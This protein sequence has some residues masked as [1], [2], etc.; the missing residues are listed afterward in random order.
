MIISVVTWLL[1]GGLVLYIIVPW[2]AKAFLRR[3]FLV[4][5]GRSGCTCLTFDDGPNPASTPEILQLLKDAGAKATFFVLGENAAKYPELVAQ[6]VAM[7]HQV[8]EH[9]YRHRHPWK[10]GPLGSVADIVTGRHI[11]TRHISS[12]EPIWFRPPH[13]K[14]NL[15]SLF[16]ILLAKRRVAFWDINSRDYQH[17]SGEPVAALVVDRLSVGSVVLLHDGRINPSMNVDSTLSGLKSIL[18]AA[19]T[20][21]LRLTTIREAFSRTA[22]QEA[23][24]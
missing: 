19:A 10:T 12:D 11:A 16:Y 23:E 2:A 3:R 20:R 6:I 22:Q 1:G 24:V 8:G 4:T 7:G 9:S 5:I 18:E 15:I 17:E 14:L 21:G 13:G